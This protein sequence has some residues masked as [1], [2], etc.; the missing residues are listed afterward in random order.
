MMTS[1]KKLKSCRSSYTFPG[2][3]FVCFT[4]RLEWMQTCDMFTISQEM[5]ID[6]AETRLGWTEE[7]I[8]ANKAKNERRGR[9]GKNNRNNQEDLTEMTT[10]VWTFY[11][12]K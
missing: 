12:N 1:G 2:R 11:Q 10:V 3:L 5:R 9:D 7:V 4:T 6:L 8:K